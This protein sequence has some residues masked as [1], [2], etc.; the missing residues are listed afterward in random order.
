MK[1]FIYFFG[2]TLL[3]GSCTSEVKREQITNTA[4]YDQ[5]LV[6][7]EMPSRIEA[8]NEV[9]FWSK[10]LS[11]DS[12]GVGDL[13]P[14]AG[15]YHKLFDATGDPENLK[16]AERA[17][18]KA[19]EISA[20]NKD[21]YAR[22]LARTYISQH[23][24]KEAADILQK[25]YAG[26]S[27]KRATEMMLFDVLMELGR[28]E[29]AE[30]YLKKVKNNSDYNYLIRKAKWS[31]HSG[32]LTN[33]INYL[34]SARDI[35]ESR[36]SK[37]LKI[38][39]YSNLAD[40]YGHAGRI[41]EAYEHYLKTLELQPDHAYAKKGIAWIVY[42][43]EHKYEEAERIMDSIMVQ[44][45]DPSYFLLKGDIYSSMGKEG[46]ALAM[47]RAFE[48]AV[49]SG[50][51]DSM[52]NSNLIEFY[53]ETNPTKAVQL[54]GEEV[55]ARSTPGTNALLAYTM[56]GTGDKELALDIIETK[57][58]GKTFEP[59]AAYFSALVYKANG[60]S[61]KVKELKS[62]LLDASFELGPVVSRL[63]NDF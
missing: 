25:S 59:M 1:K 6:T 12:S 28:F 47:Q 46:E 11:E 45:N 24:F 22:G 5:Y 26:V 31:D 38:W 51:Y 7:S 34:E 52:Y 56:L 43:Y 39:T 63:V 2:I 19:M 50:E 14:L 23:R 42:S 17:Y 44:K 61:E 60:N 29:E 58:Q 18:K 15:A 48:L 32:D 55:A 53:A 41:R 57:V 27:S 30:S 37:G 36:N 20:N 40:F 8:K 54:A 4:D 9:D 62:E 35:A 10:R 13:G 16:G 21:I 49:Q 3:I 33:A